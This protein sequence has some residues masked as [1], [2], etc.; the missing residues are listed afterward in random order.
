MFESTEHE[1]NVFL[2]FLMIF[3]IRGVYCVSI[4]IYLYFTED[5]LLRFARGAEFI[6]MVVRIDIKNNYIF[7]LECRSVREEFV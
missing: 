5:T 1:R 2:Q 4:I 3:P 7:P 6:L